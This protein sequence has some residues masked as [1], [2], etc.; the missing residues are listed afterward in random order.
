MAVA[1]FWLDIKSTQGAVPGAVGGR[2]RRSLDVEKLV[3][4]FGCI[5][6]HAVSSHLEICLRP[7]DRLLH[8]GY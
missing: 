1:K 5:R 6:L 7:T 2:V 3:D 4:E 8:G